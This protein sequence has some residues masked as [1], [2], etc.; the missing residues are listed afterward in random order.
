M[1]TS[2][3]PQHRPRRL[4]RG[5]LIRRGVA[6]AAAHP[7]HLI[8]PLFVSDAAQARPVASMP[9]IEQL[10]V[11][12]AIEQMRRLA[13][14]GLRQ[15]ILFGVTPA[16]RKDA[17]GSFAAN[18]D[19][20]VNR[21]LAAAR[22]A[23]LD[24]LL[25]ADL[26]FCEYTEHGHCGVLAAAD[27][28]GIVDNDATLE[29]LGHTACAQARAGA[30]VV[31]PSG[32]MDGQVGAI[33]ASLDGG[34]Y[35]NTAILA[36]SI[37]YAS[38]FYGP[39]RD[40]GE[41]AMKF[42]DR[43][44]YQMDYRRSREWRIELQADL[45]QGADMV[46][47]KPAMAYLDIIHQVRQ[48]CDV[49]VAAYQVS[50]EY[51]M[52]LCRRPARL[53]RPESGRPG[54]HHRHSPGRGGLN[55]YLFRSTTA[56]LDFVI[57]LPSMRQRL[58]I[59]L[60]W[61][62][63]IGG[64]LL[65]RGPLACADG[66]SGLSLASARVGMVWA[67]ALVVAGSI[68]AVAVAI[69]TSASGNPLAGIFAFAASL[70]VLAG[71]GGS[72]EGWMWRVTL[73]TAYV[74]LI[75]EMLIWEA[76]SI[77]VL[78][79]IQ[80]C[81]GSVRRLWPALAAPDHLGESTRIHLPGLQA[82]GAGIVCALVSGVLACLLLPNGSVGQA[83]GALVV[84]FTIGGLVGHLV[85]PHANPIG[86]LVSPGV[87]AIAGYVY[88]LINFHNSTNVLSAWYAQNAPGV[89]TMPGIALV[90][91]IYYASAGLA[92]AAA[93]IGIAQGLDSAKLHTV[94]A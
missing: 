41:G 39:F 15:F 40:A 28:H 82:M 2:P 6:D 34:G 48:A 25:Y 83:L 12:G 56:G 59:A 3:F 74:S 78:M 80:R 88:V 20:P 70:A 10:P 29:M 81:R 4:R 51:A 31:A 44:G 24:V 77:A 27:P 53:D 67:L 18:P 58:L 61:A 94:H 54:N 26:C 68:P 35:P 72:I 32:M 16:A 50:G 69:V 11:A 17:G 46:M 76:I 47:I 33:R 38:S 66:S 7:S 45:D 57:M 19:A 87:V 36:Y 85:F 75:V 30:D 84:A 22:E 64:W 91:P 9:G 62:I 65:V 1:S 8:H 52:L 49:P 90:L 93:G 37:K 42:G 23:G 63:G 14:R 43:R 13:D 79:T 92:G 86:I 5:E 60:A 73:P 21:A 89:V 71:A 55:S